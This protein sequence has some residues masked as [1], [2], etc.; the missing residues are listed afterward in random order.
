MWTWL[1]RLFSKKPKQPAW[2][3]RTVL[4]DTPFV[5]VVHLWVNPTLTSEIFSSQ[6]FAVKKWLFFKGVGDYVVGNTK[7]KILPGTNTNILNGTKHSITA[8]GEKVEV[9]EI[10]SGEKIEMIPQ[11][12]MPDR[13][14]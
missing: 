3:G 6:E 2:G 8:G 13:K 5:K 14:S 7:K 9:L 11:L 12:P 10:Q 4:W 1:K